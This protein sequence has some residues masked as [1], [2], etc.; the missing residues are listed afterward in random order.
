MTVI[1]ITETREEPEAMLS[2]TTVAQ[3]CDLS[4]RTIWELIARGDLPSIK[5]GNSRR[6][7]ESDLN[8]YIRGL[9]IAA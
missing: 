7:R 1:G 2:V 5:I 4:V 9:P 6:V 3:R 8:A